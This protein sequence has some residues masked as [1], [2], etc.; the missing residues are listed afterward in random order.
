MIYYDDFKGKHFSQ[1]RKFS[2]FVPPEAIE[3]VAN[4]GVAAFQNIGTGRNKLAKAQAEAIKT[5]AKTKSA[6]AAYTAKFGDSKYKLLI[7]AAVVA[8][9]AFILLRK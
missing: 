1:S 6:L 8:I 9:A 4:L 3:A 2:S 7:I 5:D